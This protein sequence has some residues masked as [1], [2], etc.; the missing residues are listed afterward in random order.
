MNCVAVGTEKAALIVVTTAEVC[1][2]TG[3]SGFG[4]K[5]CG[6]L[7]AVEVKFAG[8]IEGLAVV[9]TTTGTHEPSDDNTN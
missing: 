6:S 2:T 5:K 1:E 4:K 7:L 3:K 9:C 8:T